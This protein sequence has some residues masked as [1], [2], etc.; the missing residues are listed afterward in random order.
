M[1]LD[2]VSEHQ[3]SEA[4]FWAFFHAREPFLEWILQLLVKTQQFGRANDKAAMYA[5]IC[6]L[7]FKKKKKEEEVK[8]RKLMPVIW[9]DILKK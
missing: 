8:E 9:V 1:L 7:V 4:F 6:K 5:F 2:T 3:W